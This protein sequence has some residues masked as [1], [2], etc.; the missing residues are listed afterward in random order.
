MRA[1]HHFPAF[2][3]GW[4]WAAEVSSS[5][6]FYL[7]LRSLSPEPRHHPPPWRTLV[8]EKLSGRRQE[9]RPLPMACSQ[10]CRAL[11]LGQ[12]RGATPLGSAPPRPAPPG[13]LDSR[14]PGTWPQPEAPALQR[15]HPRLPFPGEARPSGLA[16]HRCPRSDQGRGR[17]PAPRASPLPLPYGGNP[18]KLPRPGGREGSGFGPPPPAET[19][20]GRRGRGRL[21]PPR[22]QTRVHVHIQRPAPKH[23]DS[24]PVPARGAC[25]AHECV[26][27]ALSTKTNA[28]SALSPIRLTPHPASSPTSPSASVLFPFA[29]SRRLHSSSSWSVTSGIPGPAQRPPPLRSP[30]DQPV[31]PSCCSPARHVCLCLAAAFPIFDSFPCLCSYL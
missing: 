22:A 6:F 2:S 26:P 4:A 3:T 7:L 10:R 16:G 28:L 20:R 30:R 14:P 24:C 1:A 11:A 12:V 17:G 23:V 25:G 18:G 31:R 8:L 5:F 15:V 9:S 21:A 27:K 19:P 13:T 29:T